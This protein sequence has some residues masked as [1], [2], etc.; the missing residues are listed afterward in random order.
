M[1][2]KYI[3]LINMPIAIIS[4]LAVAILPSI[5]TAMAFKDKQLVS[6]KVNFAFRICL[7]IAIPAAV[8]F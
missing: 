7:L 5:S 4:A 1:Y 3:T 2:T 6:Q 8:G